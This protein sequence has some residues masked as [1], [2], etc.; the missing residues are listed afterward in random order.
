ME[1]SVE[2]YATLRFD[3]P[4]FSLDLH[5]RFDDFV[6]FQMF[7]S[8]SIDK[9]AII[10]YMIYIIWQVKCPFNLSYFHINC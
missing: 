10:I 4:A 3:H 8:H 2:S 5:D 7:C 6:Q 9:F 1:R